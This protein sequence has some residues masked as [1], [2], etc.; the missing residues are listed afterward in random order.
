VPA[1]CPGPSWPCPE[2]PRS[3]PTHGAFDHAREPADPAQVS[4]A[5]GGRPGQPDGHAP[6]APARRPGRGAGPALLAGAAYLAARGLLR[7]YI[8]P[9]F[10]AGCWPG[11]RFSS[12]TT[13]ALTPIPCSISS[14]R[15]CWGPA[16]W[17]RTP[18]PR[19]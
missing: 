18:N 12:C 6:G 2:K 3:T 19:P 15:G 16:S 10:W 1:P 14:R 7:L 5:G 17:P 13:P 11:G 9:V 4:G 8:P